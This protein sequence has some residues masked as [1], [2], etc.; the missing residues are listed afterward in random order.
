MSS[1]P[2]KQTD[3]STPDNFDIHEYSRFVDSVSSLPTKDSDEL[4]KVIHRLISLQEHESFSRLMTGVI[5][6]ASESGE[7]LDIMKKV[8]FQ[9]KELDEK[10]TDHLKK[11]LGDVIFY[12]VQAVMALGMKPSELM[13]LN[14][15]KLEARFPTGF[16]VE[17]SEKRTKT[18]I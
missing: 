3:L 12:W 7:T 11:E 10:T 17:R 1:T 9:G 8:L 4:L 18:D 14:R 6:L 5:G 13:E 2:I 15:A 16:D